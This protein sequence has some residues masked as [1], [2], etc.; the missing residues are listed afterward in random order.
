MTRRPAWPAAST[1]ANSR[2]PVERQ[3]Q[4]GDIAV[5]ADVFRPCARSR[6]RARAARP[7]R[8]RWSRG[9]MR[10]RRRRAR[11][12]SSPLASTTP[13]ARP[14]STMILPTGARSADGRRRPSWPP[15]AMAATTA[16]MPP[17]GSACAPALPAGLAGQPVERPSSEF[18]ERGPRWL[19]SVGVEGE[20]ALQPVVARAA[21]RARRRRS[22]AACAGSRACPPCRAASAPARPGRAQRL[23]AATCRRD[24][25]ARRVSNGFRMPA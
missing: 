11:A 9:S 1:P 7:G 20:Q 4:L 2:R 21:R 14:F 23:A 24:R 5:H 22:S 15:R 18:G 3:M 8:G 13:T 19:P 12:I 16:P 17:C 25:A 6:C 10:R